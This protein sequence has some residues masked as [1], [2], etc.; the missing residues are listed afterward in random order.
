MVDKVLPVKEN[1][2]GTLCR[3]HKLLSSGHNAF[4]ELGTN[5]SH[6]YE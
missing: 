5:T 1:S 6:M 2:F 4:F 3:F